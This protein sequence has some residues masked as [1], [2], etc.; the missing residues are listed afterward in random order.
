ME[1]QIEREE[2]E[3]LGI[4]NPNLFLMHVEEELTIRRSPSRTYEIRWFDVKCPRTGFSRGANAIVYQA[5]KRMGMKLAKWL[6]KLTN[7]KKQCKS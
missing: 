5:G 3:I 4:S 2:K 6:K 1:Y 7:L